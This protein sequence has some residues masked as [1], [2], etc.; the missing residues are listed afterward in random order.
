MFGLFKKESWKIEG[1]A[2]DF[3]HKVFLQLPTDFKFLADG[4]DNGLY[5]RFSVNH[6]MKGNFYSIGFDPSQSDKSMT[7]GKQFELEN[8]II[9][10][11]GQAYPL[12]ITIN[13][14]L[15]IG[16]EIEKNILEFNNFQIELSSFRKSKSRFNTN[17][18]IEKLVSDLICEQLDLTNLG[19]LDVDGKTYYQIKEL[20]NGNFIAIDNKGQVFGLIH[21]PYKIELINKSVRQFVK[22]VNGGQFEFD[23]Y[24]NKEKGNA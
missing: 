20:E 6:A 24:L 1:K 15:W 17:T 5:K 16:F 22:D 12:N 2:H 18:N 14:G 11:D 13:D 7:K 3:F 10:Q 4:L 21:A 9:K 19:E 8:I 23:K